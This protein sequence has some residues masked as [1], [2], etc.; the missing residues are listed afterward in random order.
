[1]NRFDIRKKYLDLWPRT[2]AFPTAE[3]LEVIID[4]TQ[5]VRAQDDYEKALASIEKEKIGA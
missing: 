4:I 5:A 1:V 3:Q 2:M